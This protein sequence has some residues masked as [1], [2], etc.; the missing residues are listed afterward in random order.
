MMCKANFF[1][2]KF[3]F[4]LLVSPFCLPLSSILDLDR[5]FSSNGPEQSTIIYIKKNEKNKILIKT[6]YKKWGSWPPQV[7][8]GHPC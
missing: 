6:K 4:S 1:L 7:V 5:S 3:L 8:A 2:K